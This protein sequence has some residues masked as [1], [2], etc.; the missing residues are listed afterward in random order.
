MLEERLEQWQRRH[1]DDTDVARPVLYDMSR[2]DE[3]DR[4]DAFLAEARDVVVLDRYDEMLR[5]LYVI[6]HPPLKSDPQGLKIAYES[7]LQSHRGNQEN[8]ARCGVWA[9]YPWNREL[10]H[11]PA[12]DD[13]FQLR[14]ARN[15]NLVTIEEQRKLQQIR[16]GI[17][18]LSV[19]QAQALTLTISGIGQS[20]RMADPDII[21]ASN[22]NRMHATLADVGEQK[23]TVLARKITEL[24]PFAAPLLF[25]QAITEENLEAFLLGDQKLDIVV[26]AFDNIRMKI[27]LRLFARQHRIAVLMATDLADGAILDIERHDLDQH[28]PM[29]GGRVPEKELE[30]VPTTLEYQEIARL[31]TQMIGVKDISPRMLDSIRRVGTHLA[32]HPQ[33]ALASFLGGSLV[34]YAIKRIALGDQLPS[35][36]SVSF[37]KLFAV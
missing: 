12:A 6:S 21:E 14:T 29:F 30:N 8:S 18:G 1:T 34:T 16:I 13:Y 35:R 19:G 7:W 32:G 5:E 11:V 17:I 25:P 27:K 20:L 28:T 10:I 31:A 15:R 4:L 22:L 36:V 23:T 26:D 9:Y 3:V 37:E 33:L 24:D 2:P